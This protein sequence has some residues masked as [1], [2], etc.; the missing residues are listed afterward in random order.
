MFL[1]E[2]DTSGSN[3]VSK[4]PII[5]DVCILIICILRAGITLDKYSTG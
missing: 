5:L 3:G 2:I 4:Y 1:W